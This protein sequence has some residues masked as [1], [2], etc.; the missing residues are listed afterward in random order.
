MPWSLDSPLELVSELLLLLC[1]GY[2]IFR[3]LLGLA[4]VRWARNAFSPVEPV[5]TPASELAE[6]GRGMLLG[7]AAGDALGLPAESLPRWLVR[8]RYPGGPRH[9]HG[10]LR[11]Y[12]RPGEVSDDTQ[13]TLCLARCITPDGDYLHTRFLDELRFWRGYRIGAGR[14]TM[15]AAKRLRTL[16]AQGQLA[17]AETSGDRKSQGNGA[18]MRV[19]PLALLHAARDAGDTDDLIADVR[20]NA[21]STHADEVAISAAVAVAL[22]LHA[23]LTRPRGDLGADVVL[24]CAERAG[25]AAPALGAAL[26]A[27]TIAEAL[28]ICG[29]SGH[30]PQSVAAAL[31][32]LGHPIDD[33]TGCQQAMAAIFHGGG[34]VD[35]VAAVVGAGLGAQL[36]EGGLPPSWLSPLQFANT[37]R[38][39]ADRLACPAPKQPGQGAIVELDGDVASREVDAIVDAWNR[40]VIPAWLL[41]PQGVS[42]AIKRAGGRPAMRAIARRAPLPLG[43]ASETGAGDLAARWVIHVAGI[44]LVWRSS[45][46]TVRYATRSALE[47]ARCLG[48]RSVA[49]P[50]IGSGSG[51]LAPE[52]A[53][54]TMLQELGAQADAFD[55]LE[56]VTFR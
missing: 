25:F 20:L 10:V 13:L 33:A 23:A 28:R 37:L 15:S 2:L 44:N 43:C 16:D 17:C 54:E 35:S 26:R 21:A 40:N 48:A 9:R 3:A 38:A 29:T 1:G 18:A 55:R 42:K 53:R 24:R 30:A 19:A 56:L 4:R 51:G 14:A 22:V 7:V 8:L 6:R 11:F 31:A 34:D 27:P 32:V 45:V 36:G 39:H 47:L 12:R 49:L 5:A 52:L 41:L 50:L 46:A